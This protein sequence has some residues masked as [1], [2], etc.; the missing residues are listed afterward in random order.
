MPSPARLPR[1]SG[2]TGIGKPEEF[3]EIARI[4]RSLPGP[5]PENRAMISIRSA[6]PTDN[7]GYRRLAC[8][9]SA[10]CAG[11]SATS[12]GARSAT[13]VSL[14]LDLPPDPIAL[15]AG[16]ARWRWIAQCEG[17]FVVPL[18]WHGARRLRDHLLND[19][20]VL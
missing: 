1:A 11:R 2:A 4:R 20:L 3:G 12:R 10:D 5:S 18:G 19:Q 8:F 15:L 14:P 16:P 6:R 7:H 9:R 17:E 13:L